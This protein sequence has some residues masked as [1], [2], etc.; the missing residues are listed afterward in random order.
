MDSGDLK[1]C[2]VVQ[3]KKKK[4]ATLFFQYELS[5]RNKIGIYHHGL[6]STSV[7]RF[8]IFTR[9]LILDGTRREFSVFDHSPSPPPTHTL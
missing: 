3:K 9:I 7:L 8:T 1:E 2:T 6:L 5:Y 4:E